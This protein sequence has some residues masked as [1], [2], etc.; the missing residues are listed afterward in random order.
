MFRL[1][2]TGYIN[3]EEEVNLGHAAVGAKIDIF[4]AKEEWR[5]KIT[6]KM[7]RPRRSLSMPCLFGISA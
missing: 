3:P 2:I 4:G 5:L 6:W 1:S 7:M